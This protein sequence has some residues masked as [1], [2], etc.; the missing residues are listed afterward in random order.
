MRS[1]IFL[2]QPVELG[3]L[4]AVL[5]NRFQMHLS[6]WIEPLE[7]SESTPIPFDFGEQSTNSNEKYKIEIYLSASEY[8]SIL[9]KLSSDDNRGV[10]GS[11]VMLYTGTDT[12]TDPSSISVDMPGFEGR[13]V[14]GISEVFM[15]IFLI[16]PEGYKEIIGVATIKNSVGGR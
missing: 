6:G 12:E 5:S 2:K 15:Q 16:N 7:S 8:G 14:S 4:K 9:D 13:W 3:C 10:S 1:C 11:S